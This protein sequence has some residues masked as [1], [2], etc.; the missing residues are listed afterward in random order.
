MLILCQSRT[1]VKPSFPR[2]DHAAPF[3]VFV[4]VL[5]AWCGCWVASRLHVCIKT[6]LT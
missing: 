3:G 4:E 6:D 2:V 1:V 5:G